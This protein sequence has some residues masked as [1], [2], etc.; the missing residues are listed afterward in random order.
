MTQPAHEP[1]PEEEASD[2]GSPG[3]SGLHSPA[4][5]IVSQQH[6]DTSTNYAD[7][8]Q[9]MYPMATGGLSYPQAVQDDMSDGIDYSSYS[10]QSVQQH[11]APSGMAYPQ[12]PQPDTSTAYQAQ[13]NAPPPDPAPEP[14]QPVQPIQTVQPVQP[15]QPARAASSRSGGRRNLPS[16]AQQNNSNGYSN[17]AGNGIAPGPAWQSTNAAASSTQAYSASPSTR[18]ARSRKQAPAP[19]A[20]TYDASQ[21]EGLQAASTLSRAALQKTHASPTTRTESPL[22]A[23]TQAA[24]VARAKSRHGHKAHSRGTASPFQQT[25]SAQSSVDATAIY[26]SSTTTDGNNTPNYDQYQRFNAATTRSSQPSSRVAYDY[27]QQ[28]ATSNSSASYPSYDAYTS[29]TQAPSTGSLAAPVTQPMP[30]ASYSKTAAASSSSG[31]PNSTSRRGG[32]SYAASNAESNT[33]A[34]YN[35]P[36]SSTQQQPSAMQSFNGRP[37][38]NAH[39]LRTNTPTVYNSQQRTQQSRQQQ[40]PSYSAY[41]SQSQGSSNQQQQQQQ[42]DW[43]GFGSSNNAASTYGSNARGSGY[44]QS[45]SGNNYSQRAMNLSGNT[46]RSMPEQELYDM[47]RNGPSH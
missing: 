19:I 23:P 46:Y 20:P 10:A 13:L 21:H 6:H 9:D 15:P 11:S 8:P 33:N 32:N 25:S 42:Q 24:N 2:L 31:W 28:T 35:M 36:T 38:S 40:Q 1:E 29:R 26:N 4:Q 47:L 16:G 30:S 17:T 12:Q 22:Q 27:T 7:N 39:P 18:S 37:Q 41:P 43:Y 45:G 5:D 44:G 3:F 14:V 34:A